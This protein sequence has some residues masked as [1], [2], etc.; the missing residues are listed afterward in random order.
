VE[1]TKAFDPREIEQAAEAAESGA[2]FAGAFWA[3]PRK[4]NNNNYYL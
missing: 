1:V 4:C 2:A 3:W